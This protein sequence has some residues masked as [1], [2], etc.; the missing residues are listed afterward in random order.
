[1]LD[2]RGHGYHRRRIKEFRYHLWGAVTAMGH[3]Q[4]P[5]LNTTGRATVD[6]IIWAHSD[7]ERFRAVVVRPAVPGFAGDLQGA[8]YSR[9]YRIIGF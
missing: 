9:N 4:K 7:T 1:M 2:E 8:G 3:S 6:R 5:I